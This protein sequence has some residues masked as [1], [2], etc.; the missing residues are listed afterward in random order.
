VIDADASTYLMNVD[1][2][3][4]PGTVWEKNLMSARLPV[5]NILRPHGDYA[6]IGPRRRSGCSARSGKWQPQRHRNRNQSIIANTV[7]RGRYA[8]TFITFTTDPDVHIQVTD[9]RSYVRKCQPAI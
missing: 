8:T 3:H 4:W 1:L 5:A 6:I 7:M 9:G 2:K